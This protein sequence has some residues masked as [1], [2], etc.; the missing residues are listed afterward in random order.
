[1]FF[2]LSQWLRSFR[3]SSESRFADVVTA[4]ILSA[5]AIRELADESAAVASSL[6]TNP[7]ASEAQKQGEQASRYLGAGMEVEES[8]RYQPGDEVRRLNWRL[9]ARTGQAYTKLYQEERQES[10]T[11]LLDQR[12]SMRFGTQSQLKVTQATRVA[13]FFAWQAQNANLPLAA[14]ALG[15][16]VRTSAI[17]EGKSTFAHFMDFAAV[18]CPPLVTDQAPRLEDEL[19]DCQQRLKAGDRLMIISDFQD[20]TEQALL[21]LAELQ[22]KVMVKAILIYDPAEK[23]LPSL[24]GITLQSFSGGAKWASLTDQQQQQYQA[25]AENY[26]DE[27]TQQLAQVGVWVVSLSTTESLAQLNFRLMAEADYA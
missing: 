6:I 18:P 3:L 25:W 2:G 16:K 7:K 21:L 14:I 22:A 1:M 23:Q 4:P 12:P 10:W 27:K 5:D 8:R 17:F 20:L 13:G 26:F 9:M 11:I 24:A 15:E 19:L